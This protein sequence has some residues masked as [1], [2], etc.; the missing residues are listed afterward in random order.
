MTSL[1]EVYEDYC[2]WAV[3]H[4][5]P[6]WGYRKFSKLLAGAGFIRGKKN[7]VS[8]FFMQRV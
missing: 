8:H 2:D 6:M 5:E 3:E 7:N 4:D 1:A